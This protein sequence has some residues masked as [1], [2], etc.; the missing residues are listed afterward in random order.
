LNLK[1]RKF[2]ASILVMVMVCLSINAVFAVAHE[3]EE[4][5][6]TAPHK[7][8]IG[9]SHTETPGHC[10]SCPTK[11]HPSTDHDHFSCDHHTYVSLADQEVYRHPIPYS[12]ECGIVAEP[13]KFIPEVYLDKFIPPQNLA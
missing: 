7:I 5:G 9:F 10:P 3:V 12:L 11:D 6:F 8:A 4:A 2:I 1:C 13:F